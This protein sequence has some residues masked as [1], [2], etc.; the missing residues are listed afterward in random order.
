MSESQLRAEIFEFIQDKFDEDEY[1]R[2]LNTGKE[3]DV[4]PNDLPQLYQEYLAKVRQI[5]D[6]YT[7]NNLSILYNMKHWIE[8]TPQNFMMMDKEDMLQWN[9]SGFTFDT[10]TSALI[11]FHER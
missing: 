5:L 9:I 6:L 1:A 11:M 7:G 8:N 10:E 3:L 4:N 2:Y